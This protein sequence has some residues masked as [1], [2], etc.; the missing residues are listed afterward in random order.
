MRSPQ[1]TKLN[2]LIEPDRPFAGGFPPNNVLLV[3][4]RTRPDGTRRLVVVE[5]GDSYSGQVPSDLPAVATLFARVVVPG[6]LGS[7]PRF[8]VG[9]ATYAQLAKVGLR[10]GDLILPGT[11]DATDHTHFTI[12]V[13]HGTA[14]VLIDGW[15]MDD[16]T[17]RFDPQ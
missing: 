2:T 3:H 8:A 17:V 5:V 9:N 11:V 14:Q 15:L 4:E 16:D 1:W 7:E 13:R 12:P 10:P 6:T